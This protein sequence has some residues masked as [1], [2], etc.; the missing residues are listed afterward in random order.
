MSTRWQQLVAAAERIEQEAPLDWDELDPAV[1][2]E[3]LNRNAAAI[4]AAAA[5]L[6][7]RSAAPFRLDKAYFD[8]IWPQIV[9]LRQ[10]TRALYARGR[11]AI[12][13]GDFEVALRTGSQLLDLAGDVRRE[14]LLANGLVADAI[15]GTDLNVLRKT[16]RELDAA[17][18]RRL[19]ENLFRHE[20]DYE[21]LESILAP[22]SG[23]GNRDGIRGF[24]AITA[25]G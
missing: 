8:E 21:S 9:I 20:A 14:A 23:M 12:A 22:R 16:R 15:A 17:Q 5:L 11:L 3:Y 10:F 1:A 13:E 18:R 7:T 24:R 4:D 2:I 6:T 25:I 19:I